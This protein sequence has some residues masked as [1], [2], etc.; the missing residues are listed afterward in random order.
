MLIHFYSDRNYR[1]Q[2]FYGHYNITDCPYNCSSQ[3]VCNP[4]TH[5]CMCHQGY[6]GAGC[7]ATVCPDNCNEHGTCNSSLKRCVCEVGFAG[8]SCELPMTANAAHGT[9]YQLAPE[10]TGFQ[11][12]TGHVGVFIPSINC[13]YVFGGNTLN[14]LLDELIRYCFDKNKWHVLPRSGLWPEPR[15]EHAVAETDGNFFIFGGI[16]QNK[17]HSD[18]LWFYNV[19]ENRWT[20]MA[21]GS[22]VHP[23]GVASHTLTFVDSRWL[24]LFGGRTMNGHFLSDMY[25]IDYRNATEWERVES[26]GGKIADRRLVGHSAVYHPSSLSILVFGGFLPD[27]AKFPKRTNIL[28]AYHIVENYWSRLYFHELDA[29]KDRAFHT[30]AI[31]GNY[32]VIHGGNEHI[33]HEEEI[34]YDHQ[35]YYYHLGCHTWVHHKSLETISTGMYDDLLHA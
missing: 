13:L 15:H 31:M 17:T 14:S 10:G 4:S 33:H 19:T 20:L 11:P 3:G 29:P 22:A 28:N 9:W 5:Q 23:L 12:R 27:Y 24:Y 6:Q 32:M 21:G 8:H 16:L 2:G 26:R 30:A 1:L 34:C 35:I 25:R 18:E 7:E